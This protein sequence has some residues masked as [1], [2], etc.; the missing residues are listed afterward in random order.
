M[1]VVRLNNIEDIKTAVNDFYTLPRQYRMMRAKVINDKLAELNCYVKVRFDN[2]ILNYPQSERFIIEEYK[3]F[4]HEN[5]YVKYINTLDE[6]RDEF[7]TLVYNDIDLA[8]DN[9]KVMNEIKNICACKN[10]KADNIYLDYYPEANDFIDILQMAVR[11]IIKYLINGSVLDIVISSMDD[12]E[13]IIASNMLSDDHIR[14]HLIP[15]MKLREISPFKNTIPNIV[16]VRLTDLF[17]TQI[18]LVRYRA[19]DYMLF[20]SFNTNSLESYLKIKKMTYE[21]TL[22]NSDIDNDYERKSIRYDGGDPRELIKLSEIYNKNATTNI[23][24]IDLFRLNKNG[25]EDIKNIKYK[26]KEYK[27][28]LKENSQFMIMKSNKDKNIYYLIGE[29]TK[30]KVKLTNKGILDES[31][32]ETILESTFCNIKKNGN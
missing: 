17:N 15:V 1:E 10:H 31:S 12:I 11:K 24:R 20:K 30:H 18:S 25:F 4:N 28:Y 16:N 2:P 27:L 26:D 19:D 23:S 32:M 9:I 8:T 5:E 21:E 22:V 6:G 13:F 3:D 7:N 29:N 14:R